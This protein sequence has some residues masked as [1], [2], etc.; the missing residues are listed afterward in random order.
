MKAIISTNYGGPEVLKLV[1]MPTPTPKA[2]EVQIEIHATAAT[3]ADTMMRQ[4]V[5]R[6]ARIFLGLRRPKRP[7]PG[8]AFAGVVRGVGA[9]VTRFQIGDRI[10]GETGMLF[11]AYAQY[12][13]VPETAAMMH[14]PDGLSMQEAAPISDGA[15]TSY[16]FLKSVGNVRAGDRVLINGASGGLGTAAVQIAK[17]LGAHV[18]AV[19]SADNHALVLALGA[20]VVIDRKSQDFTKT[21]NAYDVIFDTIGKSSFA[22]AKTALRKDG[23][24]MCPV[25]SIGLLA[26]QLMRSKSRGKRAKFAAV[27]MLPHDQIIAIL[28][29]LK[30]IFE[31]GV[32][33]TV[34]EKTYPLDDIVAAHTHVDTG[35][36]RGNLVI[37]VTGA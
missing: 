9:G 24:Y 3:R 7:I 14:L 20:D 35:R 31:T 17:H 8:T 36:K 30:P 26:Q 33:K 12:V 13:V 32:I 4:G 5:P 1:D 25:L 21:H 11:S 6:F 27:G 29:R 23:I 10:C 19:S 34:I 22:A 15:V 37:D 18:T 28:H 16:H 2:G